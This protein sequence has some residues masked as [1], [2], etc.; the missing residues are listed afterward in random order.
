VSGKLSSREALDEMI[1]FLG[2][3]NNKYTKIHFVMVED[4]D[5]ISRDVV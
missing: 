1:E 4:I 3:E 5:R 2:K